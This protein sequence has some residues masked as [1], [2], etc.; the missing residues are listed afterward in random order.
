MAMPKPLPAS[1]SLLYTE[2]FFAPEKVSAAA[3]E[4]AFEHYG[5]ER[6]CRR[7]PAVLAPLA[8][9][10]P[11][12]R[13]RL[14]FVTADGRR[15]PDPAA[16]A[17][18]QDQFQPSC[19]VVLDCGFSFSH[20][21]PVLD[22][23]PVLEAVRRVNLG[24]KHL[25]NHLKTLVSF[26]SWNMM[27][28]TH[29]IND[30]KEKLCFV[31]PDFGADMERCRSRKRKVNTVRREFVLPNG[32]TITEGYVRDPHGG[33]PRRR[34][35]G[36]PG[37]GGAPMPAAAPD[38]DEQVLT[39]N[40]E[41]VSVPEILFHP[42]DI[43]LAQAGV[44]EA[45]HQAVQACP[46][47]V[48]G[49]LYENVLAAGGTCALPGFYERVYRDVRALAPSVHDVYVYHDADQPALSAWRGG[50]ALASSPAYAEQSCV[51]RAEYAEGGYGAVLRRRGY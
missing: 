21:V 50:S 11:E 43:G 22:G 28:E 20:V 51:S 19:C 7:A 24:G 4:V 42:T 39:M 34:V 1:S 17:S 30:V 38:A 27:D 41:R 18:P 25:T 9:A 15:G 44:A 26:R 49:L 16:A 31:S 23:R 36:E 37:T 32:S 45:V 5:F 14:R 2:P 47:R 35:K 12:G 13:A 3:A 29:L 10:T 46:E 40:N 48:R 8:Y 33:G 6:V